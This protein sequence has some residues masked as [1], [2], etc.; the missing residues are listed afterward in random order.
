MINV[1]CSV[2]NQAKKNSEVIVRSAQK[3][4][5][6]D[7][8]IDVVEIEINGEKCL[9]DAM[10]IQDAIEKCSCRRGRRGPSHRNYIPVRENP[11]WEENEEE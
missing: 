11:S 7:Y 9:V 2:Q 1:T 6:R 3:Q 5:D 4:K 8:Y 10:D